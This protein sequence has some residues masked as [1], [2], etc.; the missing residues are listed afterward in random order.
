MVTEFEKNSNPIEDRVDTQSNVV[1]IKST[2]STK[3][4]IACQTIDLLSRGIENTIALNCSSKG[5]AL[6]MS[7]D[8][9]GGAIPKKALESYI[10]NNFDRS[11]IAYGKFDTGGINQN[12]ENLDTPS[13]LTMTKIL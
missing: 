9:S 13:L 7:L 1:K 8:P 5:Q 4:S 12:R 3:I 11:N 6:A 2:E 10:E